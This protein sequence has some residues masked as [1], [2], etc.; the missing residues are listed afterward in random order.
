MA[1]I[2][3]ARNLKKHLLAYLEKEVHV[4]SKTILGDFLWELALLTKLSQKQ[5]WKRTREYKVYIWSLY[6]LHRS[7]K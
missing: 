2:T 1:N 7:C 4:S 5:N 6:Y 3:I